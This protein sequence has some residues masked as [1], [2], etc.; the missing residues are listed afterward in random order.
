MIDEIAEAILKDFGAGGR[1]HGG[2]RTIN[3][4]QTSSRALHE[5]FDH[6]AVGAASGG[7]ATATR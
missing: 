4:M 7:T 3:E 2:R 5:T 6:G 1:L